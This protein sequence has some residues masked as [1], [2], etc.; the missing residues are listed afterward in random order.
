MLP[1]AD[2]HVHLLAGLDD[3]PRTED[4]A[5]ALCRKLISEGVSTAAAVAHQ[6]TTYPENT[7]ARLTEAGERLKVLLAEAQVPLTIYTTG[8]IVLT[9]D[10]IDQWHA[11][12]LQSVGGHHKYLLVEM[13]HRV[14]IDP[15]PTIRAFKKLGVKIIIAHAERYEPMLHDPKLTT[16]CIAAGALIQ[17]TTDAFHEYC[18]RDGAALRHWAKCGMIHLIGSDGH[19]IDSRVPK[20]R[21]GYRVLERWIGGVA[22]E[23][24]ASIW[25]SAVLMGGNVNPPM[26]KLPT[27]SWF[28]RMFGF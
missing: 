3:G 5:V 18:D 19:R 4:E 25:G 24:I 22:A 11:G 7:P 8:E 9:S 28:S 23:R 1:I 10:L 2:T 16:E 12:A 15:R 17:V 14:F 20:H 26:P 13:P 21:E 27:K 6:N